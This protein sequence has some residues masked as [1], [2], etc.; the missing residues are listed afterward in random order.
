MCMCMYITYYIPFL[1]L[2]ISVINIVLFSSIY[3]YILLCTTTTRVH[4][5][6]TVQ[7]ARSQVLRRGGDMYKGSVT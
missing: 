2:S 6:P 7:A 5:V 1:K 3:Y 4:V